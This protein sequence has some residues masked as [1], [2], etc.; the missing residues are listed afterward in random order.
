MTGTVYTCNVEVY[1]QGN[2]SDRPRLSTE[3]LELVPLPSQK[4]EKQAGEGDF[5]VEA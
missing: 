5:Y 4:G 2:P 3:G 1:E